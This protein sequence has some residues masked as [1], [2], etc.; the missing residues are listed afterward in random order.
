MKTSYAISGALGLGLFLLGPGAIPEVRAAEEYVYLLEAEGGKV[1]QV[2]EQTVGD[3]KE[4]VKKEI[5]R[6]ELIPPGTLVEVEKGGSAFLTC[7][8]CKVLNLTDQNSPLAVKME[9]FRK[10][11]TPTGKMVQFFDSALKNF[12]HPDSKPSARIRFTTRGPDDQKTKECRTLW[13]PDGSDIMAIDPVTFKWELAGPHVSFSVQDLTLRKVVY[14]REISLPR[15]N[16]PAQVFHAGRRYEW[17]LEGKPTGEKCNA[18][19]KILTEMEFSSLMKIIQDLPNLLPD[20]IDRETKGRL[21]AGYL[22]AEGYVYDAWQ[23]LERNG[24]SQKYRE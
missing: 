2:T 13:P 14:A 12:I 15:I 1:F 23:W 4:T 8:G 24:I 21:Q 19:F 17:S 16:V 22:L 7:A 11:E 20:G 18:A 9:D 10:K 3:R 5:R 6:M